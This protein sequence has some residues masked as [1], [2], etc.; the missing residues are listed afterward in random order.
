MAL[1]AAVLLVVP[2]IDCSAARGEV[3][4]HASAPEGPGHHLTSSSV[5]GHV[6]AVIVDS[7]DGHC[8]AHL[9]HCIAKSVVRGAAENL[10]PQQLLFALVSALLVVVA[11][12]GI[13]PGGVRGP[14]ISRVPVVGGRAT[15][16]QF[17]I[18]RR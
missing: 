7:V 16:T 4:I 10:P 11:A 18:A 12:R 1:L 13:A 3:H 9:D 17:C 15:L 8:W 6:H 2:M 14:P 5:G